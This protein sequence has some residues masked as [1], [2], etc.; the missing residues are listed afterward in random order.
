MRLQVNTRSAFFSALLL[1]T[2]GASAQE[3]PSRTNEGIRRT[4][5]KREQYNGYEKLKLTAEQKS[6]LAVLQKEGRAAFAAIRKGQALTP[7]EKKEKLT[8]LRQEQTQK[9][10]AVLT[11]A[12]QK[13]WKEEGLGTGGG[14]Q[15]TVVVT[16]RNTGSK[17]LPAMEGKSAVRL[18]LTRTQQQKIN[19]LAQTFKEQA[20]SV[21]QDPALSATE[22]E[23]R[24]DALKKEFRKKRKALLTREQA[25]QWARQDRK[26]K[27]ISQQ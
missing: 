9:Q 26:R 7:D 16:R 21:R 1:M 10:M 24:M 11:P 2:L 22:K 19:E 12:Q 17:A 27:N 18:N 20:R 6:R 8:A 3:I 4:E 15:Q 5:T 13:I 14:K 25:Q 23:L